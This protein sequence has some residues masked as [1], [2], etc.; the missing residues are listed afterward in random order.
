MHQRL[1]AAGHRTRATLLNAA[2]QALAAVSACYRRL[3]EQ[4]R[5]QGITA[6]GSAEEPIPADRGLPGHGDPLPL[7]D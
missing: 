7:P 2:R 6:D 4:T 1:P 5:G 3:A